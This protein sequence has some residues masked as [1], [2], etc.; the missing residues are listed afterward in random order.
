MGT[1]SVSA[2]QKRNLSPVLARIEHG[3]DRAPEDR[4]IPGAGLQIDVR[5]PGDEE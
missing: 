3:V 4:Q 1:G 2:T 5:Q